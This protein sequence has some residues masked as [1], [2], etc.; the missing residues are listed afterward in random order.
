MTER[1]RDL[2]ALRAIEVSTRAALRY[3]TDLEGQVR[4]KDR[5]AMLLLDLERQ[6]MAHGADGEVLAAIEYVR[7]GIADHRVNPTP[8]PSSLD[9]PRV[10]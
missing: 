1:E 2:I 9:V 8:A 3:R 4:V 5:A 6:V 7:E 10:H